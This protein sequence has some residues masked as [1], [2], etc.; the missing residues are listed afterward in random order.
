MIGSL[1]EGRGLW[2]ILHS[3]AYRGHVLEGPSPQVSW[4]YEGV[5]GLHTEGIGAPGLKV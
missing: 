3:H 4:V 2:G 1:G 5:G